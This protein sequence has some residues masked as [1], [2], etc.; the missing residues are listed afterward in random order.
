MVVYLFLTLQPW[1]DTLHRYVRCGQQVEQVG[2][3]IYEHVCRISL[4]ALADV[5]FV[6]HFNDD[7][8]Y[9]CFHIQ[10]ITHNPSDFDLRW[11]SILCLRRANISRIMKYPHDQGPYWI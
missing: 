2:F 10:F 6:R 5:L 8:I 11:S 9:L 3:P 7:L 4:N 1:L